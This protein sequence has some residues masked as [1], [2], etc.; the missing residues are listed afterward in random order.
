MIDSSVLV[1]FAIFIPQ[2]NNSSR[3]GSPFLYHGLPVY[4]KKCWSK[5]YLP[6]FQWQI[7]REFNLISEYCKI[8]RPA[9][10]EPT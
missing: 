7:L 6:N 5:C 3:F 1:G 8:Y 4:R 2:S 10:A 9:V